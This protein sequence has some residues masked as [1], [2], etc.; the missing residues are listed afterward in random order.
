MAEPRLR[1]TLSA[2][3][4]LRAV[5]KSF[6]E[7]ED[8]VSARQLTLS[9]CLM[10]GLAVF[11]LK[12]PSL[13]RFDRDART[14]ETVRAN[15]KTLYGVERAPC[16]TALR[17]RLDEVDPRELR[18]AFKQVFAA[19]QRGKGLEGFT[20]LDGHY[21]LSVDG[22]GY[23]SSSSVHC[24]H[25]CK[26]HHK[27]GRITYY[28]QMLGAVV[29]HPE[30]REVF[31]L[32]PEPIV[33]GDGATKND[34][35]RNAAKRGLTEI[36]REHPHLKL[37]VVED[38]LASNGPHIKLLNH[39]APGL[40]EEEVVEVGAGVGVAHVRACERPLVERGPAVEA[41]VGGAVV[42][43]LDPGPQGAVQRL[44]AH[45]GGG[46]EGGEPSCAQGP[47]EAFDF[48]LIVD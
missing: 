8:P 35:E 37:V 24:D 17:E 45:R 9:D 33:K 2:P 40:E 26:K 48:P 6:D 12:Y 11:G 42:L 39:P 14:D 4:L 36:R 13:L 20:W 28:H 29:V 38:G 15:L 23:F 43:A 7:V 47:E 32:A 46:G 1:K 27:D 5:R 21:L 19:L 25:C 22:T 31:P 30:Q 44:Q 34:C 10:S 16:D 3:G 18:V 41:A